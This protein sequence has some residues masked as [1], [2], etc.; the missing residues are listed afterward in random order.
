MKKWALKKYSGEKDLVQCLLK[1]RKIKP[2]NAEKF[3]NPDYE[4]G[5]G[6]PFGILNMDRATSRI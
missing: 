6:D 2:D 3:F 5:L 4:S 1:D